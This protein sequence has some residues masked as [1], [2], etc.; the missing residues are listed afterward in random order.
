[1]KASD[2]V[3]KLLSLNNVKIGFEL[4]GGMITHLVDSINSLNDMKLV[5]LH[6]EQAVA[7]AAGGVARASKNK[8]IGLALATSGPGATNLITGI[9]DCWL[10]NYP[11]IFITGQ[12]NTNELKENKLIRQQGFQELDIVSLVDSITK[13]AVR[14]KSAD[15]LLYEIQK[16]INL[17]REGR[18]GP[19]L[20]DIPMDIQREEINVDFSKLENIAKTKKNN[21]LNFIEIDKMLENAKKPLFIIGGGACCE[22]E[23]DEWQIMISTL[24]IPH[25]SSLKGSENTTSLSGYLG[26][27]G[28]YGTRAANYAV[29][30]ADLVIVLGSRLDVRQTGAN[31]SDF[32]RS[33]K[34]I[35]QID[36]DET[37][38][39]NRIKSDYSIVSRCN[40]YF[41]HTLNHGITVNCGS[42]SDEVIRVFNS[43]F[44]DEYP[45]LELSPYKMMRSLS[46]MFK[47]KRTH[48]VSD[49]GNHQ[50]W[51][52]HSLLLEK[53]HR[54]HHSGGLGSM[55]FSLP[56]AIGIYEETRDLVVSISGDGGFQMNIQELDVINREQLPILILILN[57]NSLGMVKNFQDLYFDGRNQNT[58]WNGYTCSFEKIG[59]AYGI[60]SISVNN[61]LA[62]TESLKSYINNPR[63]LLVEVI[64]KDVTSCKPRVMFGKSI[65]TQYPDIPYSTN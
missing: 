26:M 30:N 53:E 46:L 37:Q 48:F 58:Y 63:A 13:Y 52:A 33:S 18:P 39:N 22:S 12:V 38:I 40:D 3:A 56:S 49:V 5:S 20:I 42:W 9:S 15:E 7:F 34:K 14:I 35:I 24:N 36:I 61:N 51:I 19:V 28:S 47:G 44:I 6:H 64:L 23:F 4:I 2:A 16:A 8:N 29:Q 31:I 50:M 1:M 27:L 32:A 11:C 54:S 55:G 41:K 57:N 59:K 21:S 65:D 25:V 62:F 60:E 45:E 10:D 17:S 43:T